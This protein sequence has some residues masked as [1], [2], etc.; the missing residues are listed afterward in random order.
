MKLRKEWIPVW[1]AQTHTFR[2]R[3][4]CRNS[5]C[6]RVKFQAIAAFI[7]QQG[8]TGPDVPT[9]APGDA[10]HGQ[11]LL[12]QRGCLACHSIGEGQNLLGGDFAANLSRVGEKENYNYLVRW[13][14]IRGFERG[15]I[16]VR[17]ARLGSGRLRQ[18]RLPFVFDWITRSVRMTAPAR[19]QQRPYA[20]P[21][22]HG[23]GF[24]RYGSF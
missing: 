14:R 16:A 8:V 9:A 23:R 21:A 18:T 6:S 12:Q 24:T 22:A 19:G 15:R 13:F 1:L 17:K 7:W 2:R 4:K 10:A 5:G 3:R 20:Q 11:D